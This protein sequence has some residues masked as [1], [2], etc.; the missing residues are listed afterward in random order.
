M[1]IKTAAVTSSTNCSLL[2]CIHDNV[3]T[4]SAGSTIL[5]DVK[6]TGET[7]VS[8]GGVLVDAGG[9][10]IKNGG[11]LVKNGGHKVP[12]QIP[13]NPYIHRSALITNALLRLMLAAYM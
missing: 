3:N 8:E 9:T 1:Q 4:A 5:F 10:T 11:L 6:C 12:Y 2:Q 13:A 7:V